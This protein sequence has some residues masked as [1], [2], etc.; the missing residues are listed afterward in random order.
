[1][2]KF[3]RF[4]EFIPDFFTDRR[5]ETRVHENLLLDSAVDK[6]DQQFKKFVDGIVGH[7]LRAVGTRTII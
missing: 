5:G 4:L 7:R 2:E 6:L 3:D 1:M